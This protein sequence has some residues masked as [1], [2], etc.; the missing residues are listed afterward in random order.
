MCLKTEHRVVSYMITSLSVNCLEWRIEV[1][2]VDNLFICW[3]GVSIFF[4]LIIWSNPM[5]GASRFFKFIV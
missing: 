2:K 1:L 3:E 4:K 5:N